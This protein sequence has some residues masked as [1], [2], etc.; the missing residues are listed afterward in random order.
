MNHSKTFLPQ[1]AAL[2]V[3]RYGTGP[4][5]VLV[6]H[7]WNGDHTTYDP[8]LPYLDG[9]AFSWAFVDLRGYG[10]SKTISGEYTVEEISRDCIR[11]ADGLGWDRFHL[12]G[13]SMTGMA[14]E[15]IAADV[16]DRIRSV[17]AVCPVSAAGSALDDAT[18]A[19]FA[20]T[21]RSDDAF[22]RLLRH[23]SGGLSE[24]WVAMK[25]AQNRR[26][27]DP[28]CRDGYLRMFSETHFVEDVRGLR[29]PF[30]VIIGENDPGLDAAAME[31][32]FLA[33]HPVAELLQIPN[34]GHY[35]MQECPPYFATVVERFLAR[36]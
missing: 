31:R 36:E 13:H 6:L 16:P 17:V 29:T 18:R 34:C 7:D 19:F 15:R 21:T 4:R 12:L 27:V 28:A 26:T 1:A 24:S 8:L 32:T 3:T 25:L 2:H 20:S 23:V 11:V 35:P 30:L 10:G 14:V 9:T 33:W 22:C 5:Q